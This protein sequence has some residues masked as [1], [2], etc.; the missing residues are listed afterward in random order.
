MTRRQQ[1][2]VAWISVAIV[3]GVVRIFTIGATPDPHVQFQSCN[4]AREIGA[5]LPLHEGDPG[6]NPKLDRDRNGE[7]C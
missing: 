2:L 7:A 4:E 1:W 5:V 6:W 3:V